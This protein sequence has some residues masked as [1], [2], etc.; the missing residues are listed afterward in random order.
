[1]NAGIVK[2]SMNAPRSGHLNLSEEGGEFAHFGNGLSPK[3]FGKARSLIARSS[4]L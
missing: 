4:C 3:P 1:M 2:Y